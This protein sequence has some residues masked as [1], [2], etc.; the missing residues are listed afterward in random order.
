M[1]DDEQNSVPF[2]GTRTGTD[3]VSVPQCGRGRHVAVRVKH[4]RYRYNA[5]A[6]FPFPTCNST[7]VHA[8]P[9]KKRRI[10]TGTTAG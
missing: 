6:A 4:R 9:L 2:R 7:Q 8:W 3:V 10:R 5:L 1:S